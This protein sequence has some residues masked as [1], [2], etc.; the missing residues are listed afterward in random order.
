MLLHLYTSTPHTGATIHKALYNKDKGDINVVASMYKYA[1]G[2]SYYTQGPVQYTLAE[3][4]KPHARNSKCLHRSYY[5]HGNSQ[6]LACLLACLCQLT[7]S[8]CAHHAKHEC[9]D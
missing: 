1:A 6:L 3:A 8:W 5:T 7:R 9:A 4:T 2:R